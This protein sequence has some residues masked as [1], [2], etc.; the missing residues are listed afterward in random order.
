MSER[1]RCDSCG[2]DIESVED[3]WVEWLTD[4]RSNE[5]YGMRLVHYDER[6][7]YNEAY[8]RSTNNSSPL[9]MHLSHF[10]SED[11]FI[12]LLEMISDGQFKN[13]DTVLEMIKRLFV[14]DYEIARLYFSAAISEGYFEP[15]TKP[16]F[17]HTSDIQRTMD[18]IR[19]E[20]I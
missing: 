19:D 13:N 12:R 10:Y 2:Q 3:G 16:G 18:Y 15:N 9:D 7:M 11:G 17:Y 6:C 1:W 5:G 14:K 8:E 4:M 20:G